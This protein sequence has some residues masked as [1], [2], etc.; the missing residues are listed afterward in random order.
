[1]RDESTLGFRGSFRA[2]AG[3]HAPL[4]PRTARGVRDSYCVRAQQCAPAGRRLAALGGPG[5]CRAHTVPTSA[6]HSTGPDTG[7]GDCDRGWGAARSS[8]VANT[9]AGIRWH[10]VSG[11]SH[12]VHGR[13][14][15]SPCV[16]AD[17]TA[18]AGRNYSSAYCLG[19]RLSLHMGQQVWA[20]KPS[21][22]LVG[23]GFDGLVKRERSLCQCGLHG[24]ARR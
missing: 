20:D 16:R 13:V 23:W 8:Y 7:A 19:C 4:P 15:A 10:G 17:S 11:K 21:H 22:W 12:T 5:T 6:A 9:T 18:V 3:G 1:M 2:P 14:A 24:R